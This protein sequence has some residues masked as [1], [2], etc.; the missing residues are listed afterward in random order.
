MNGHEIGHMLFTDFTMHNVYCEAFEAGRFYPNDLF[1]EIAGKIGV[2]VSYFIRVFRKK[3]SLSPGK[4]R[5]S[6]NICLENMELFRYRIKQ[7]RQDFHA[8]M[9]AW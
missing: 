5:T 9:K 4:F 2:S 1:W 8:D 7:I 6:A 3:Y